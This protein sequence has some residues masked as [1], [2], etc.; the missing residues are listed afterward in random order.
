MTTQPIIERLRGLLNTISPKMR[1]VA[2]YIIEHHKEAVFM[3]ANSLAKKSGVSETTVTRLAYALDFRGYPELRRELQEH[4]ITYM[5]LPRYVPKT[6]EDDMLGMVADMER[7]IIEEM[8]TT[9][10]ADLFNSAVDLLFGA[11]RIYVVGT[12]YNAAPAS[13]ASYFLSAVRKSVCLIREIGIGNFSEVQDSGPEDVVLAISTARYPKDTQKILE[14][15]KLK[16][17]PIIVITDSQISPIIY[18]ADLTMIVPMK[19]ISFIDP[20]AGILVL[21]HALITK[22]YIKDGN[23]AKKWVQ[24]FNDFMEHN[25]YNSVKEIN[26]LDLL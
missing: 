7:A 12:H 21:L 23:K 20:F 11:E 16:K 22:I 3:N 24:D 14:L 15:F 8:L 6:A 17:T 5:D 10:P 13:Y 19:F 26:L 25:D 18:L 2:S 1:K 4:T 9:I